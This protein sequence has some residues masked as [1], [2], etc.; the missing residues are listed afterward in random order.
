M[1]PL[2]SKTVMNLGLIARCCSGTANRSDKAGV[3]VRFPP[4]LL[5]FRG[6]VVAQNSVEVQVRVQFS[7]KPL[8]FGK[9]GSPYVSYLHIRGYENSRKGRSSSFA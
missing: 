7:S 2:P 4:G 1:I 8:E 9:L 3:R 6:V 5:R